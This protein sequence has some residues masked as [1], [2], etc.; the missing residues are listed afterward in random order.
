MKSQ[1]TALA[2]ALFATAAAAQTPMSLVQVHHICTQDFQ[3]LCPQ[4]HPGPGGGLH[5]CIV[6]HKAE[7]SQPCQSAM[8]QFRAARLQ[9]RQGTQSQPGATPPG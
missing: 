3:R 6:A 7:F 1:I 9:Q 2:V 8:Q 4:A 5:E